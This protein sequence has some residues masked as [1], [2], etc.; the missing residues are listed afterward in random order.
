MSIKTPLM[1]TNPNHVYFD[2][3]PR[4]RLQEVILFFQNPANPKVQF[5]ASTYKSSLND[6]ILG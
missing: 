3:M 1:I 4:C 2:K 6:N 5:G